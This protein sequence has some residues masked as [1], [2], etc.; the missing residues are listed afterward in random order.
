MSPFGKPANTD[1][2]R[3]EIISA[4]SELFNAVGAR[5]TT[6]QDVAESLNKTKTSL[7]HYV[8]TK[9][10][11]IFLCYRQSCIAIGELLERADR[12]KTGRT[13]ILLT[14]HLHAMDWLEIQQGKRAHWAVLNE[15]PLLASEHREEIENRYIKLVLKMR[16]FVVL[17]LQDGSISLSSRTPAALCVFG[18]LGWMNAWLPNVGVKRLE[19][20]LPRLGELLSSGI[21]A[22]HDHAPLSATL[23]AKHEHSVVSPLRKSEHDLKLEAFLRSGTRLFNQCGYKGVSVDLITQS[24]GVTKGAFYY[25]IKNKDDLLDQC[26]IRTFSIID[27][28]Q[29]HAKN[30]GTTGLEML[31]IALY[32]LFA[33][34]QSSDG[35]LIRSALMQSLPSDRHLVH[36]VDLKKVRQN[37][38]FMIR[39]G[40]ADGSIRETDTSVTVN[41]L[42]GLI[43][44]SVDYSVWRPED[45]PADA[46]R[47]YFEPVLFGLGG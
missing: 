44:S 38:I 13:K 2:K 33:T 27:Y 26:F 4:A 6:L 37:F 32:G 45:N 39:K 46:A 3:G 47:Q 35:I 31:Q 42:L 15:I 43:D 16:S 21:A 8:K 22:E 23:L 10:E 18:L 41:V 30:V 20:T 17:G 11:L 36:N 34:Q 9:E 5:T 1:R 14:Y 28:W 40:K 25:Y 29:N 12:A 24:L 7:Y 19:A